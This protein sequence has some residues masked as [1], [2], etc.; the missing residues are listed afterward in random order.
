MA[1]YKT[2][3]SRKLQIT[4]NISGRVRYELMPGPSLRTNAFN[5]SLWVDWQFPGGGVMTIDIVAGATS[6][7]LSADDSFSS[8]DSDTD[9][10]LLTDSTLTGSFEFALDVE[11]WV[12]LSESATAP[13]YGGAS[14]DGDVP[15]EAT[16]TFYERTD[17]DGVVLATVT[18]N[19]RTV[20]S[21]GAISAAETV[22]GSYEFHVEIEGSGD[23]STQDA[24]ITDVAYLVIDLPSYTRSGGG[25]TISTTGEDTSV[26]TDGSDNQTGDITAEWKPPQGLALEGRLRMDADAY[27]SGGTVRVKRKITETYTEVTP[28]GGSYSC[29]YTQQT[30]RITGTCDGVAQDVVSVAEHYPALYHWLVPPTGE[31]ADQWRLML[32]GAYYDAGTIVQ[33]ETVAL[34][35]SFTITDEWTERTY[36]PAESMAGYRYLVVETGEAGETCGLLIGNKSWTVTTD[37]AGTAIFDLCGPT[38]L[39]T[40]T[41]ERDSRWPLP[42]DVDVVDAD[43]AMWGVVDVASL[44]LTMGEG[45]SASVPANGVYLSRDTWNTPPGHSLLNAVAPH[46]YWVASGTANTYWRPLFRG[47]TDGRRSLEEADWTRVV[48][49]PTIHTAETIEEILD[50]VNATDSSVVRNPG[51][52]TVIDADIDVADGAAG[53]DWEYNLLNRNRNASWLE[54]SGIAY[55]AGAW[56]YALDVDVSAGYT[57]IA[58]MLVDKVSI[59][60]MCGDVFGLR[61][62]GNRWEY[63]TTAEEGRA[64]LRG[65]RYMRGVAWGL[66]L[67]DDGIAHTGAAVSQKELPDL[68]AAGSGTSDIRGEYLTG[69]VGGRAGY[70]HRITAE[71]GATQPY[72]DR[73]LYGAMRLRSC[74]AVT[75][76][77]LGCIEC[78]GPRAWLHVGYGVR[79]RTYALW[80]WTLMRESADYA[81]TGWLRFRSDPRRGL[82]AML[83]DDGSGTLGVWASYDGGMTATEVVTMTATSACI[84]IDS[85]RGAMVLLWENGANVQRQVSLDGGTTWSAAVEPTYLGSPFEGTIAD[86]AID[87]RRDVLLLALSVAGAASILA[88]QDLGLTWQLVA[89]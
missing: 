2:G 82:L 15:G 8:P 78:D 71:V 84:E 6:R 80:G 65:G 12:L 63:G 21:T 50:A 26:V 70:E 76:A 67:H 85:T 59:Y 5:M 56:R 36:S 64:E 4:G 77:G 16:C 42:T 45:V 18:L 57:L 24:T 7:S 41:D 30:H 49:V 17:P 3:R 79:V 29:A 48:G 68:D 14:V 51:W 58:Q 87:A 66:T 72:I 19:G 61:T 46:L 34:D 89:S 9:A 38:N 11:E 88:S 60:P 74:F 25:V 47:D 62:A 75:P 35:G 10:T 33:A 40:T 27:T 1:A 31:A 22:S 43:G 81:I 52:S 37:A 44:E 86:M 53:T 20:T 32:R 28:G 13:T 54:G 39:A 69:L 55:V 73:L 83:S 23:H